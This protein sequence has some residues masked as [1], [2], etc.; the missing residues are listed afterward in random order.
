MDDKEGG[1]LT[2]P[3]GAEMIVKQMAAEQIFLEMVDC[4]MDETR[5]SQVN[6]SEL[7]HLIRQFPGLCHRTYELDWESKAK[8]NL[9]PLAILCCLQPPLELV[10]FVYQV[11]PDALLC[12]ESVKST[13]P[14]HYACTFQ[15]SLQVVDWMIQLDPSQLHSPRKDGMYAL[16]LAVFFEAPQLV[17][18][19]IIELWPEGLV[20][21]YT[22]EWSVLHAAAAGKADVDL[23]R[24]LYEANPDSIISLDERRRTPLHQAC[25]K[26]GNAQVVAFLLSKAPHAL[27]LEDDQGETPMFRAVRNQSLDVIR[28]LVPEDDDPP[29][30]DMGAQL[31]CILPPWTTRRMS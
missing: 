30:D 29:L 31:C 14:F 1:P 11:F 15:A 23:V 10:R 19:R 13:L 24:R 17:V 16:H 18:N 2:L 3:S 8:R 27:F 6:H 26:K 4:I 22:G 21:D 25:W 7:F 9:Y 20:M 28:L 12:Q 5:R